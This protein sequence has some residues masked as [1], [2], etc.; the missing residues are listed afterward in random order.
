MTAYLHSAIFAAAE[1]SRTNSRAVQQVAVTHAAH[2][3]LSH[4]LFALQPTFIANAKAVL[5]EIGATESEAALGKRIGE[6]AA[7][8]I[9]ISRAGDGIDNVSNPVRKLFII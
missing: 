1:A 3:A 8:K 9:A 2:A 4:S 5:A 6:E 7:R